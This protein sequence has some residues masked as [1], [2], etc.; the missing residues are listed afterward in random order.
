MNVHKLSK[1]TLELFKLMYHEVGCTIKI[2]TKKVSC[3]PPDLIYTHT[4]KNINGNK[5]KREENNNKKKDY[6]H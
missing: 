1:S 3:N 2:L 6:H 5:K 4:K